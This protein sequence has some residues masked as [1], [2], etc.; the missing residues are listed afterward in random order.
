MHVGRKRRPAH[1]IGCTLPEEEDFRA[2]DDKDVFEFDISA[3]DL[4]GPSKDGLVPDSEE[5]LPHWCA[6]SSALPRALPFGDERRFEPQQ[7]KISFR[8]K[9]NELYKCKFRIQVENGL[10]M[11]FICRGIGSYDEEDDNHD[12]HEA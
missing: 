10:T 2:L 1:V 5:R 9:K 12:F 3:G 6:K 11:D 7:V 8:P 4:P